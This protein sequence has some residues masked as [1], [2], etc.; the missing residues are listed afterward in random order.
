MVGRL[1]LLAI[2]S[3]ASEGAANFWKRSEVHPK[4]TEHVRQNYPISNDSVKLPNLGRKLSSHFG[5][6]KISSLGS[7]VLCFVTTN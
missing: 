7:A 4:V 2:L 1:C 6:K 5:N 3:Q